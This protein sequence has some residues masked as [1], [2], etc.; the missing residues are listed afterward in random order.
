MI[1]FGMDPQEALDVPRF[2]ISSEGQELGTVFLEEGISESVVKEL[3]ELGHSVTYP[4][5]GH[6]R[7]VFGRGQIIARKSAPC[8]T[9]PNR[10]VYWSGSDPRADGLVVGF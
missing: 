6:S 10:S 9:G 1:D 3:T 8:K 4:V 5:S 2:C 7:S